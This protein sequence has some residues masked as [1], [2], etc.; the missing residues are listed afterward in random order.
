MPAE[1]DKYPASTGRRRF[2]K[3]VVGSATL[4]GVGT[5]A[6]AGIDSATGPT[7]G[8]GGIID[9][10]GVENTKGPAPRGMPQIPLEV[11]DE[12]YLKGVWPEPETR[13]LD[14]G[15]EVVEAKMELGGVTYTTEWFQYCGIQTAEGVRPDA[16][17]DNYFRYISNSKYDWQ[18]SEVEGDQKVHVDDFADYGSWGNGIGADGLGKPAQAK[19][20]SED[21]SSAET[22]PVQ[23]IRSERIEEMAENNEWIAASTAEGFIANLNK[24]THF[25]CVPTFKA[26]PDSS[27]AGAEDRIYC[28]CHQSVYDPFSIVEESFA[29]LPIPEGE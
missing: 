10:R 3:G 13:V 16:D 25:C 5:A 4:A 7:G 11:D 18:N 2:V 14:N 15:T 19:W 27:S 20:R 24:C 23:L 9:F 29:A 8:G 17:Q 26:L 6:A 12:G 28:Q 22:L 21:V 1:D